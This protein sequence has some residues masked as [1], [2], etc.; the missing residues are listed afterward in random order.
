MRCIISYYSSF[1]S[2]S[3]TTK[4]TNKTKKDE[5]KTKRNMEYDVLVDA[6]NLTFSINWRGGE[7]EKKGGGEGEGEHKH[8]KIVLGYKCSKIQNSKE[9]LSLVIRTEGWILWNT[10]KWVNKR[11]KRKEE[12]KKKKKKK[13]KTAKDRETDIEKEEKIAMDLYLQI[14]QKRFSL[15]TAFYSQM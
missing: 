6:K 5:V 13:K 15:E 14:Y 11:K 10:E 2:S 7:R 12:L 4:T 1:S 3:I 9:S 8:F